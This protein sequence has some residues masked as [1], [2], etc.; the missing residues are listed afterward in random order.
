MVRSPTSTPGLCGNKAM[1]APSV[2]GKLQLITA[3]SFPLAAITTGGY[4]Q[5]SNSYLLLITAATIVNHTIDDLLANAHSCREVAIIG[6]ST[7]MLLDVF[8]AANVRLLCGV[9]VQKP[10]EVLR[11]VSEGGGM[12]QFKPYVRKVSLRKATSF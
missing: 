10:K 7:P 2:L 11:V 6:P 8:S 4:R 1:T 12:Q 3:L 9:V 5:N